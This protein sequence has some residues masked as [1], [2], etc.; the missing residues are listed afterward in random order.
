MAVSG[1]FPMVICWDGGFRVIR[2]LCCFAVRRGCAG[3][4][5]RLCRVGACAF[6][7]LPGPGRAVLAG[8]LL[9]WF[10]RVR[11]RQAARLIAEELVMGAGDRR[12]GGEPVAVVGMGCRFPGG[13]ESAEELW[14]LVAE[15][16]DAMS[17][18]PADRG[19]DE[20]R[21]ALV[22]SGG[23][24][25]CAG[26]R[27]PGRGGGVR[28]GVLRD[29]PAGGAGDGPA[30]AAAAGGVLGGAGASR[31]RPGVAA[32]QP[33]RGVRGGVVVRVRG[34]DGVPAGAEGYR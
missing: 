26:G 14:E 24:G 20:G 16:G 12:P 11:C 19:W 22:R 1:A 33:D 15:G 23:R 32:G 34:A 27:V 30:A 2:R 21:V 6:L 4:G 17:G 7:D 5:L 28:R 13:V 31:D 25:A 18:F 29:L 3:G 8:P 10:S 9:W